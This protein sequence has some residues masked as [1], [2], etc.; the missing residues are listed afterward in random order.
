M[1]EDSKI[2]TLKIEFTDGTIKIFKNV[3][4]FDFDER[5]TRVG[6]G[7]HTYYTF[8]VLNN[9]RCIQVIESPMI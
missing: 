2:M 8:I 1:I 9:V 5:T 6:I 4:R 3:S 7:G